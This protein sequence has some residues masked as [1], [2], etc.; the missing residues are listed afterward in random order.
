[1]VGVGDRLRR[2]KPPRKG[3]LVTIV[4]VLVLFA[5]AAAA[6]WWSPIVEALR[7][8]W[9]GYIVRREH[10]AP[11]VPLVSS[12]LTALVALGAAWIALARHFAQIE[13]DTQRRITE[14]FS[15]AVEQL[16]SDKLQVRLGGI[17]A[18]ER[19]SRESAAD[20]WS[21]MEILTGF[22]RERARWKG[23]EPTLSPATTL[24]NKK[25][26]GPPPVRDVPTDVAAV[27][28]VIQRREARGR[29][30]E[31]AEGR[32]LDFTSVDLSLAYLR[33]ADLERA[34]FYKA[35]MWLTALQ[36]AHLR[37]AYFFVANLESASL[38]DANLEEASFFSARMQ[39]ASL[40]R[41]WLKGAGLDDADLRRAKL[42][43]ANL[44][45]A[46][47]RETHLEGAD[48]TGATGLT[49]EQLKDAIG[50]AKT[51]LPKGVERPKH[52]PEPEQEDS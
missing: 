31:R 5:A 27:L 13:A 50:D 36:E 2:F 4:V 48:L 7:S 47:L 20:Y 45:N 10:I 6:W 9:R 1:M 28:S 42:V 35:H 21:V 51:K 12:L 44:E 43:E 38:D 15:K 22:L 39:G 29:E 8:L 25:A 3:S 19:I 14:S 46:T 18:L 17:Y 30:Q 49:K 24:Q 34:V 40:N 32:R 52:W 33:G 37:E 41:A 11:L 23:Q 26:A 16:G